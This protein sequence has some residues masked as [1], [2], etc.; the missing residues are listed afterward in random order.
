[1]S[2]YTLF[3]GIDISAATAS[4]SFKRAGKPPGTAFTVQQ[5]PAGRAELVQRLV[6]TGHAPPNTL[7]VME[8]TGTYWMQ[9]ALHLHEA[10]FCVSVVNPLQSHGFA[11][12]LLKRAK[13]DA[14]DAQTLAELAEK[15]QPA[16][17]SPPPP[18]YEAMRQRL[19]ERDA[20]M[21]MCTQTK[22]RLHALNRR[23]TV[24]A[25]VRE[26]AEKLLDTL[27]AQ[28]AEIEAEIR[29]A[30]RQD[31]EWAEAAKYL[32][33]IVGVGEITAAWILVATVNFS[34]CT[35]AKE[36][37]AFAGLVPN[38]FTSGSSVYKRSCIGHA[39]H[40]RLRSAL[41]MAALSAARYN[42]V[43]KDFYERLR[44]S[45]KKQKIALCAVAR[46]LLC[47]AFTLVTKKRFFDPQFAAKN[48]IAA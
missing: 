38:P 3:V 10:G 17:W 32:L 6:E 11:R 27:K 40:A 9:L 35:T 30:L 2:G 39:G 7:V 13:T 44:A 45:G 20:L 24:V 28:I 18:V 4:V 36:A 19:A 8:A 14:I 29:Q 26:R 33:S 22:N 41:Y 16:P 25:A 15:L 5:S 12:A 42:P 34:T 46:K 31:D 37:S 21:A 47:I 1:M 43:L 48:L 23:G